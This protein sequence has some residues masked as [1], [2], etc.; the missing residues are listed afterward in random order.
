MMLKKDKKF[1]PPMSQA[2]SNA[3]NNEHY[4]SFPDIE[5]W[6]YNIEKNTFLSCFDLKM[7]YSVDI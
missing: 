1:Q 6:S 7:S 4:L 2:N 5:N 3:V